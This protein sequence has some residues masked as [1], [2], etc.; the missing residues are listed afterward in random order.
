MSKLFEIQTLSEF[1]PRLKSRLA[2]PV[3]VI[4]GI[5]TILPSLFPN[6]TGSE[7]LTMQHLNT[8]FPSN[9]FYTSQYKNWLLQRVKY[10]KDLQRDLHM[11]TGQFIE[12]K[13]EICAG[14][15][16]QT[17]WQN[18]YKILQQE[19]VTGGTS[20]VGNVLGA[21]FDYQTLLLVGGGVLLLLALT[22]KKRSK[23]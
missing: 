7:R 5:A 1:T 4:T 8:M 22:K 21:G 11:Y 18:F 23:K 2:D 10:V 15:T 13:P 9:G 17:C 14:G 12:S 20:P 3:T 19:S 16:G 6:L